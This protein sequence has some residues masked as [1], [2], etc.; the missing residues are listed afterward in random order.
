MKSA[1]LIPNHL[2]ELR[3]SGL[4][5]EVPKFS[6]FLHGAALLFPTLVRNTPPW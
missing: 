2:Q 4:L 1:A 5:V 6:K 3:N